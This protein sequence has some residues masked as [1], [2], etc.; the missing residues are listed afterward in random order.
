MTRVL[1]VVPLKRFD[2]AKSR[3]G[4]RYDVAT[5]ARIAEMLARR[6]LDAVAD[7]FPDAA[8][9]VLGEEA[10]RSFAES[11]SAS[12][13]LES[14]AP[15]LGAKLDAAL[16]ARAWDVAY[17]VMG[18][19]PDVSTSDLHAMRD[20]PAD[21]VLAEGADGVGTNAMRL[22]SPRRF[23]LAFAEP[24]SCDIHDARARAAGL[25]VAR[26]RLSSLARDLDRPSDLVES[27][28]LP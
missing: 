26:L 22:G 14:D 3:L 17:V 24:A 23:A 27:D 6:V 28:E 25:T 8:R 12:L 18:D 9:V 1:V 11:A 2:K 16:D 7:A 19:L 21:V 20:A 15:S 5:R 13:V 10:L 4:S